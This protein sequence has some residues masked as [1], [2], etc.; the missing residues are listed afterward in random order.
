MTTRN[1]RVSPSTDASP[2]KAQCGCWVEECAAGWFVTA[3]GFVCLASHKQGEIV[4][5]LYEPENDSER[6]LCSHWPGQT[7]CEWCDL[8]RNDV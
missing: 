7:R 4:S 2:R 8:G 1:E 5:D 3:S 6:R